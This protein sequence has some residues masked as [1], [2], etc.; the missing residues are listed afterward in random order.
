MQIVDYYIST[1]EFD[2]ALYCISASETI[3]KTISNADEEVL[4]Q[5]FADI[6]LRWGNLILTYLSY[7]RDIYNNVT[8][9]T[10]SK[11]HIIKFNGLKLDNQSPIQ[12]NPITSYADAEIFLNHGL[13]FFNKAKDY[14][15]LD[16]FV[17]EHFEILQS[18]S[19]LYGA[20]ASFTKD[21]FV[22]I[23]LHKERLHLLEPLLMVLNPNHFHVMI[24]QIYVTCGEIYEEMASILY[25]Q[26][27]SYKQFHILT[28]KPNNDIQNLNH[29]INRSIFMY[30]KFIQS[31]IKMQDEKK[32][33]LEIDESYREPFFNILFALTS[34]YQKIMTNNKLLIIEYYE[35]SIYYCKMI[36]KYSKSSL[37]SESIQKDINVCEDMIKLLQETIANLKE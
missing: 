4:S 12:L 35:K 32:N 34:L 19:K 22:R 7:Q 23:D 31:I 16:G 17:T 37:I 20:A 2:Q 8:K 27:K 18:I 9:P 3:Y 10:Q 15:I 25:E 14:Y 33:P 29:Y 36:L 1:H 28:I 5:L 13:N 21:Q 6:S 11:K 30:E 24:Q 26:Y